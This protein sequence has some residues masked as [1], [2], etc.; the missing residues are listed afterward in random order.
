MMQEFEGV[1]GGGAAER[2]EKRPKKGKTK[3][4]QLK[5]AFYSHFQNIIQEIN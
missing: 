2:K 3:G 5:E 4:K 1:A